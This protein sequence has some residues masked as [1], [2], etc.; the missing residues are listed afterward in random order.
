MVAQRFL[1]DVW[2][3]RRLVAEEHRAQPGMADRQ[4]ARTGAAEDPCLLLGSWALRR[5]PGGPPAVREP[6]APGGR[7][8]SAGSG[9]VLDPDSRVLLVDEVLVLR[10]VVDHG[11]DDGADDGDFLPGGADVV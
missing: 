4:P 2:P 5:V 10:V 9:G 1:Q 7:V 3:E 6:A 11:P 8:A